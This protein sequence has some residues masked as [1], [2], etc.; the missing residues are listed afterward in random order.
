MASDGE[1]Q[2]VE[3]APENIPVA[4]KGFE[5]EAQAKDLGHV[6]AYVVRSI[7]RYMDLERLDG[8]TIAFDYD[9]ALASLDRGYDA[10][11]LLNCT[12]TE[13]ISGVAMAPVVIRDGVIKSHMV[14]HAPFVMSIMDEEDSDFKQ[15]AIHLIAHECAHV[16]DNKY[17]D[18]SLPGTML[19]KE[20][21]S[22]EDAV[23]GQ[24][25]D[26]TWSEYAACIV[27]ATFGSDQ[28]KSYVEGF[29]SVLEVARS[30]AIE[31]IKSYRIHGDL[32]LLVE[33]VGQPLCLPIKGASYLLGHLD[34]V[35]KSFSDIEDLED[36]ISEHGYSEYIYRLKVELR[37]LWEKR[38][39]WE[40]EEEFQPINLIAKDLFADVGVIFTKME[41]GQSHIDVPFTP[42]TMPDL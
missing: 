13:E 3:T 1:K 36:T 35:G 12:T 29:I 7:S 25:A 24:V 4:L 32:N 22:Y 42:E 18:L 38:D 14:F 39:Q 28:T 10:S 34:G 9:E 19:Q 6:V 31:A 26:S 27:S 33:E 37:K 15:Q 8:I 40:G 30:K 41:D 11:R 23:F 20:Y 16:E 5:D 17:K 2:L 21:L